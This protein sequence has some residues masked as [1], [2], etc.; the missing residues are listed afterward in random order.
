MSIE[1][2][3]ENN[4]FIEAMEVMED[5]IHIFLKASVKDSVHRIV[6]QLKG[7]SSFQL[8]KLFPE[9]KSRLPCMWTRSYYAGTV[10]H[11]SEETVKKYIEN[12]KNV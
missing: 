2:C 1:K 11:V 6:S 5:H 12:Q 7:I 3:T 4:Y 9:L 10:G 8:R